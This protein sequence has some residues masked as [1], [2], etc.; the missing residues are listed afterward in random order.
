VAAQTVDACIEVDVS[1]SRQARHRRIVVAAFAT[2]RADIRVI[3]SSCVPIRGVVA[4]FAGICRINVAFAFCAQSTF[5]RTCRAVMT[6]ETTGH[7]QFSMIKRR[8]RDECGRVVA[9]LARVSRWHMLAGRTLHLAQDL[10]RCDRLG[11]IVTTYA[12]CA[13]C[14]RVIKLRRL[15][16]DKICVGVAALTRI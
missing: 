5:A 13:S 12:A 9:A 7:G 8:C 4:I 10:L 1:G 14:L 3:E 15:P 2:L 11:A 6:S 16:I